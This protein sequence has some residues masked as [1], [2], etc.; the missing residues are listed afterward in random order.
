MPFVQSLLVNAP[1]VADIAVVQT[2][3]RNL[4]GTYALTIT[5]NAGCYAV[6]ADGPLPTNSSAH[7]AL[8]VTVRWRPCRSSGTR[9][10][11]RPVRIA[12]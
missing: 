8:S 12:C 4:A 9:R 7:P 11:A 3:A 1:S 6:S 10:A 2:N 5:A